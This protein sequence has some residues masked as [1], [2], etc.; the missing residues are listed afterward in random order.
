MSRQYARMV[1]PRLGGP[2]VLVVGQGEL[3]DAGPGEVRVRVLAAGVAW[4]DCMMRRGTYADQPKTPFTP[5]Y[6]VVG[7]V[8]QRGQGAALYE[9]G[10]MVMALTVRGGYAEYAYVPEAELTPLPAGL[11]PAEAVCL[12]L[13]YVTAYQLLHRTIALWTGDTILVHSAAGGVGTA[14]LELAKLDGLRVLGTASKAKHALV[15]KLGGE[16]IDYRNERFEEAIQRRTE[17]NGV[18]AAFDPIGGWHW[19][20]SRRCVR[21]GGTVVAFGSQ[22]AGK[23]EDAAAA[24]VSVLWPGRRF[25]FYSV[26]GVKKRHP[27]W[28][29]EDLAML[30][31]LLVQRRIAPI[32]GARLPWQKAAEA[33]R[34]LEEGSVQG[35]IVLLFE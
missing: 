18:V 20:R 3:R 9:D 35:K 19:L 34:M 13:N 6:D 10:R 22:A 12:V 24:V 14:L 26:T 32:I 30:V 8:D 21:R 5:G 1:C 27:A 31:G 4:A 28:F 25:T 15:A 11:D 33:N 7:V 29:R 17:G 2:E 23:M 16:P